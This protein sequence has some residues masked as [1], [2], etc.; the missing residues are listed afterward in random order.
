MPV[1]A[2]RSTAAALVAA[3]RPKQWIKNVLVLAAP[4]AAGVLDDGKPLFQTAV[5]FVAFCLAASGTYFL[6][7]ALDV[8]LDRRHPEKRHR[9]IAAGHI[10]LVAAHVAGIALI[11]AGLAAGFL[12]QWQ[13]VV[14][15]GA[16]VA[17][18]TAYTFGLKRVAVLDIVIVASGFLLRAIAGGAATGV[19]ISNWFFIV[20]AF[21]S[22]FMVSGKRHAEQRELGVDAA[23]VR[24][25]LGEY[26]TTYLAYLR[27]VSSGVVLVAYSLWAF[28][29]ADLAASSIPWFQLSIAPFA[30]A[31]LRYAMLVDLGRGAAPEELVLSDTLLLIAGATWAG[32]F[33]LGIYT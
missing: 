16:Y 6:N 26:T 24:A 4:A 22:L 8:D 21:G 29:K 27:S 25:T 1:V 19:P 14:T 3:A 5:A 28:E 9:P 32:L 13:L 17:L 10:G 7:D 23:E 2:P 31:I 15:V 12:A 11:L 18:T 33:A 30:V 20:A